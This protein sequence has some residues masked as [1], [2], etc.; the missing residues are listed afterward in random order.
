MDDDFLYWCCKN[1]NMNTTTPINND[2][3]NFDEIIFTE[4]I[5]NNMMNIIAAILTDVMK[6]CQYICLHYFI[7]HK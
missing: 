4:I 6:N 3:M 5:G 2:K 1:K 7:F